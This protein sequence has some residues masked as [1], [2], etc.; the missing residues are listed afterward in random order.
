MYNIKLTY[1]IVKSHLFIEFLDVRY[2]F[3]NG[4]LDTDIF[5]KPTDAHRFLHFNSAHPIHTFKS[6][7]FSQRLRYLQIISDKVVLRHRLNDLTTFFTNCGYPRKLVTEVLDDVFKKPRCLEY[8]NNVLDSNKPFLIPWVTTYGP[9][10]EE[11]KG[12]T[13]SINSALTS[14]PLFNNTS[15][16][17]IQTVTRRGPNLK[18][19]LFKQRDIALNG[20]KGSI[21]TKCG[22]PRCKSCNI[23][24]NKSTITINNC[25]INCA[26][27]ICTSNNIIYHAKCNSCNLSYFGKTTTPLSIRI[28]GHF[29]GINK[30]TT[31][32][33]NDPDYKI[34]DDLALAAHAHFCH[35]A[36]SRNDFN[37]IYT[38]SI[39]EKDVTP[40]N[41]VVREQHYINKYRTF[42]P[43]GMNISNPIGLHAI[44]AL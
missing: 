12:F 24:S 28:N 4:K 40:N 25:E 43:V 38:F 14:S 32:I 34:P 10:F 35:N 1:K 23:M 13:K 6:V 2:R 8:K 41:L 36:I 33:D 39:V 19:I 30:L 16:P 31:C 42:V 22:R 9:G 29:G 7:V 3:I 18:D 37:N 17:P 5:F 20:G 11:V 21:S 44:L 26:G 15:I 27:G